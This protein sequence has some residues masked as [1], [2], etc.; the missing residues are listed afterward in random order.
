M[1]TSQILAKQHAD[2]YMVIRYALLVIFHQFFKI[3]YI[4]IIYANKVTG[5][6][7]ACHSHTRSC[8]VLEK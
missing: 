6:V 8:S 7:S 1:F 3:S 4:K 2:L 5:A